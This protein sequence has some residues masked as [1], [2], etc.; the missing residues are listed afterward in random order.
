M[1]A[2]IHIRQISYTTVRERT[3]KS[4]QITHTKSYFKKSVGGSG[5]LVNMYGTTSMEAPLEEPFSR[6]YRDLRRT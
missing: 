6:V 4:C 5:S 3:M 1:N 2:V